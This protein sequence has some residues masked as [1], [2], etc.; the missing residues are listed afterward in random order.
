MWIL[1]QLLRGCIR[2]WRSRT[3][4][5][6][7]RPES[8]LS[9]RRSSPLLPSSFAVFILYWTGGN[10]KKKGAAHS[11][12]SSPYRPGSLFLKKKKKKKKQ[13]T[14][15]RNLCL[16]DPSNPGP[17]EPH[18]FAYCR[19]RYWGPLRGEKVAFSGAIGAVAFLFLIFLFFFV[20]ICI[21]NYI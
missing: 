2:F 19:I 20:R 9:F 21:P 14:A 6:P 15:H 7:F 5:A 13:W 12:G 18:P 1:F 10:K 16:S 11:R 4:C 17:P 8:R 3:D